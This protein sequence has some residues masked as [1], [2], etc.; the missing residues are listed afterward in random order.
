MRAPR[1]AV[2]VCGMSNQTRRRA[3]G[4]LAAAAAALALPI[5]AGAQEREDW[6]AYEYSATV[7]GVVSIEMS[8]R[9]A[10]RPVT[11]ETRVRF[12]YRAEFGPD[13]QL[14][15]GRTLPTGASV[16]RVTLSN[17]DGEIHYVNGDISPP[18]RI[19]CVARSARAISGMIYPLTAFQPQAPPTSLQLMPVTTVEFDTSC[20]GDSGTRSLDFGLVTNNS[21]GDAPLQPVIE[22]G[23]D[24]V[25]R[26]LIIRGAVRHSS[27]IENCPLQSGSWR[28]VS[29]RSTFSGSIKF[30]RTYTFDELA[31]APL[32]PSKPKIARRATKAE[33]KVEC[34]DGCEAEI[35]VFLRPFRGRGRIHYPRRGRGRKGTRAVVAAAV[36]PVASQAFRVKA[37]RGARTLVLQIPAAERKALLR[38]GRAYVAVSLDPPRGRTVV[39][40]FAVA[41]PR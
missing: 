2:T 5:A 40:N 13:F 4:A 25:G 39:K 7:E 3:A 16:K 34:Q 11:E 29:C 22:M 33:V 6:V 20:S 15:A 10:T 31:L 12:D 37:G 24:D 21:G 28:I 14:T 9:D 38:A 32:I 1:P 41:V 23:R 8:Q 17:V 18:G 19:D 27:S 36:R 30:A 26:D 35:G